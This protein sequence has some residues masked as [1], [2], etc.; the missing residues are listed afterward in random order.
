LLSQ[1]FS[2]NYVIEIDDDND[3]DDNNNNNNN[4]NRVNT[5]TSDIGTIN[6]NNGTAAIL[7]S[8]GAWFFSGI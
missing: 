1:Y 8:L 7:Y 5:G 6:S 3:D 4:N 2:Q